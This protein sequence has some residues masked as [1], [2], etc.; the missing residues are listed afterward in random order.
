M[1]CR[2]SFSPPLEAAEWKDLINPKLEGWE[3]LGDGIWH[4]S[5]DGTLTGYRRP[6]VDMLFGS[7]ETVT[8]QQF[9]DWAGVQAWLY[10]VKEYGEY[11]LHAEYWVRVHGNSGDLASRPHPRPLCHDPPGRLHQNAR[12]QRLR[13]ADQRPRRIAQPQRQA[14]TRSY[15]PRTGSKK[16]ASGIRSTSNHATM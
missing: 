2:L 14:F 9:K 1:S 13:G 6:A 15:R 5:E 3:Q 7:S 10:T 12:A 8:K 16:T 4:V 11:D